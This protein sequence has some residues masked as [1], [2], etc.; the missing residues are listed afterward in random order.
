MSEALGA[1]IPVDEPGR[2]RERAG[3][4]VSVKPARKISRDL[5]WFVEEARCSHDLFAARDFGP[6]IVDPFAGLGN[7]LASARACGLRAWGSD[8]VARAPGI[9][10]SKDFF[11]PRWRAPERFGTFAIIANPPFGGRE[12]V[13]R[14]I[15]ALALKRARRVAL[16]V[17]F[18]R[19]TA[20][21]W[22]A[23]LPCAEILAVSPRPS[24]WPGEI[25]LQKLVAGEPLG[26]GEADVCW[27]L[28][29][30]GF[31][32]RPQFG[33]LAREARA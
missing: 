8:L 20:A 1:P 17:P 27:L 13:I 2:N 15:A 22:L 11:S 24:L 9:V 5:E 18:Q 12:P 31:A 32:G 25:Y 6:R 16:L 21:D 14:N 29:E 10:G 33:R 30:R 28:F 23:D 7:I 4:A 3:N 26:K 19:L